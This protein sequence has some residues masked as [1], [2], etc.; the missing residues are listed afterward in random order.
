M[1]FTEAD[2]DCSQEALNHLRECVDGNADG[3]V[4]MVEF[5]DGLPRYFYYSLIFLLLYL[6]TLINSFV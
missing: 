1:L 6:L 5:R 3:F 4:S 2:G